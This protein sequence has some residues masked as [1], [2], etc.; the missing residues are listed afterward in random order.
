M[1]AIHLIDAFVTDQPFSGNPAGV[2]PLYSPA[3]DE[4]MQGVA[5]EMNQAETAFFWPEGGGYRLRWFTPTVE[6]DLC[7]HATLACAHH[8]FGYGHQE[9]IRFWTRSG[10]LVA[11][12]NGE[13]ICLDFPA[14]PVNSGPLPFDLP[15]LGP[16]IFTGR[17]I[18][19]WFVELDSEDHLRCLEP[20][21]TQIQALGKRGLIV[22]AKSNEFDFISRFFAPQSGVPEDPVT[23]SAH[24]TLASY[25]APKLQRSTLRGY[26]ASRRGGRVDVTLVG[27]RVQLSGRART[28]LSGQL[29]L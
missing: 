28:F 25:W 17:G 14:D 7:G 27:S 5:G 29:H 2:C 23:G 10:E 20:D 12:M 8:L 22:T 19:D 16:T 1:Q 24:C 13:N 21:M 9:E 4:W 26:Q 11:T 3:D 18:S 6:V 15:F